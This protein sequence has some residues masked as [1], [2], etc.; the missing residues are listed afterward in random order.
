MSVKTVM[1]KKNVTSAV[2][3]KPNLNSTLRRQKMKK[4]INYWQLY[5][6]LIIPVAYIIIFNYIPMWNSQIAFR[7]F[8]ARDGIMGSEWVGFDNFIRFFESPMM[9]VIIKNTLV[10]SIYSL[11]AMLPFPI[12]LAL[13]LKY[14]PLKFFGKTVQTITYAPHFISTVVMVSIITEVL[15]P[16]NGM[17]DNLLGVFGIDYNLN[18]MGEQSA[19]AH[20]YVWSGIWQSTGFATVVYTAILTSVDDSLHEA[21]MVDGASLWKRVWHIDLPSLKP[22]MILMLILGLGSVLNVSFEKA[23]LMQNDM[24]LGSSEMI[25]TY[26]YKLGIAAQFPDF[27]YTTAIGLFRSVIAFTLVIIV[28]KIARKVGE[29]SLW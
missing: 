26:V 1:P 25:S 14:S 16:R 6:L 13:L 18:L 3:V 12:F 28:N 9:S 20:I 4:A 5:L 22:Q 2:E 8:V 15:N 7:D 29:T 23:L 19:F 24:N 17:L 27:S 11:F 10:I 21:A